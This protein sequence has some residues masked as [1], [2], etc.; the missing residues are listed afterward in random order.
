MK[1]LSSRSCSGSRVV[2]QSFSN[3]VTG[4]PSLLCNV[5]ELPM[6]AREALV[7]SKLHGSVLNLKMNDMQWWHQPAIGHPPCHTCQHTQPTQAHLSAMQSGYF[8]ATAQNKQTNKQKICVHSFFCDFR[9]PHCCCRP[10]LCSG[11]YSSHSSG[12]A[13]S[14]KCKHSLARKMPA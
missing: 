10:L 12:R 9:F 11:V 8:G 2:I 6:K 4:T 13:C 7:S 1:S 3:L 5:S 14:C